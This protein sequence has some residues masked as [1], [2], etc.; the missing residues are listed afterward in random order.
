MGTGVADWAGIRRIVYADPKSKV[1]GDYYETH[2]DT[3]DLIKKFNEPIETIHLEKLEA[4][5]LK[6]IREW[7]KK[8][9]I[10]Y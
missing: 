9:N 1:S 6:V 7:E 4:E 8:N 10:N 3:Q 2:L 5:A